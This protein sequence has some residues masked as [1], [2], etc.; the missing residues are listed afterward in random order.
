MILMEYLEISIISLFS[1]QRN[2][3]QARST[4]AEN[5]RPFLYHIL[6]G[7]VMGNKGEFLQH[8]FRFLH[9]QLNTNGD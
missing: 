2:D 8:L 6:V 9:T 5:S 1:L 4:L 7:Y 3:T